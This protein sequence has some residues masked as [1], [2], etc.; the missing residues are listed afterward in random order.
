LSFA[1]EAALEALRAEALPEPEPDWDAVEGADWRGAAGAA[2]AELA[3]AG[4]CAAGAGAAAGG[5][6]AGA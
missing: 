5:F 6:G 2:G 1:A 3:G 4:A